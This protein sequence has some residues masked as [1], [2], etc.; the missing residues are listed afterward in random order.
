MVVS[1]DENLLPT[2]V[3]ERRKVVLGTKRGALMQGSTK[4]RW[5][6]LCEQ[7][8]VEQD[9]EKLYKLIVEINKLLE[10]KQNRLRSEPQKV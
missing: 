1:A 3:F 10:E 9:A 7:A 2:K 4:E 8:A 5:K 6:E